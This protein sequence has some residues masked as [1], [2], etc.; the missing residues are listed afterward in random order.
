MTPRQQPARSLQGEHCA[1]RVFKK[2]ILRACVPLCLLQGPG[3]PHRLDA[4]IQA[5]T[6]P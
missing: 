6:L 5:T 1:N 4:K 2:I 3:V